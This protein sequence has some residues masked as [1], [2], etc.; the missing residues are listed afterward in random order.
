MYRRILVA[1]D[2]SPDGFE[3]LVQARVLASLCDA[4]VHVVAVID[5]LENAYPV[6][7]M[8]FASEGHERSTR[9]LLDAAVRQLTDAGCVTTQEV[10]FGNVADEIIRAVREAKADLLVIGH[11]DQGTLSRWLNGSIGSSIMHHPPCSILVAVNDDTRSHMPLDRLTVADIGIGT[12][13]L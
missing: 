7:G 12:A 9:S 11:R 8:I 10:K 2:G 13:S 5:L 6:E 1:F 3:A 4:K